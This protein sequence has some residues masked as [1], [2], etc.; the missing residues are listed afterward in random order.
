ML[1]QVQA[2]L[3]YNVHQILFKTADCTFSLSWWAGE[4]V[5]L[6]GES[7]PP[8]QQNAFQERIR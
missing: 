6:N 2:E 1:P 4:M 5:G 8:A 3:T 7:R